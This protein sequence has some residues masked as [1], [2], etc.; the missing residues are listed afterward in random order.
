MK[1]ALVVIT[2]YNGKHFLGDCLESVCSQKGCSFDTLVVENG[3]SDG[4]LEYLQSQWPQVFVEHIDVNVGYGHGLNKGYSGRLDDYRHIVFLS[5]DVKVDE[6]WLYPLLAALDADPEAALCNSLVINARNGK[7]DTAAGRIINL[8]LGI[9]GGCFSEQE[10]QV[11]YNYAQ[12]RVFEGFYADLCA[13]AVPSWALKQ[14]GGFDETYYMYFEEVDLS[15]R[16]RM[17]GFKI[18]CEPKSRLTHIKGG[19]PKTY[20]LARKVIKGMDRNLLAVFFKH[21]SFF[22]LLW[23]LPVIAVARIAASFIYLPIDPR[24][25]GAKLMGLWEFFVR[26]PALLQVR[27]QVQKSRKLSDREILASNPGN[28]WSLAPIFSL[29]IARVSDISGWYKRGGA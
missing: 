4:S 17:Q 13:L 12:G 2:N 21:L 1:D 5:N 7:V 28:P 29:I 22:N 14:L 20:S 11:V 9:L 3:S 24:I 6:N 25:V 18:L 27:R 19:T 23:L 10:P 15:W 26:I 16:A 8:Y